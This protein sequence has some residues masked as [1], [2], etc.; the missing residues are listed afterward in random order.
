MRLHDLLRRHFERDARL[1]QRRT[2]NRGGSKYT[3]VS[4]SVSAERLARRL[5]RERSRVRRR[6]VW[7]TPDGTAT[8]TRRPGSVRQLRE[9]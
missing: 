9:R 2:R 7:V 1:E 5:E 4:G 6:Q 3:H 8:R